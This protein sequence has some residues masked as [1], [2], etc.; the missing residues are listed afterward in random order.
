M[1]LSWRENFI[2]GY[3]GLISSKYCFEFKSTLSTF[4][5]LRLIIFHFLKCHIRSYQENSEESIKQCQVL[6]EE[7][8][9]D[10]AVRIGDIYGFMIEHYASKERWKAVRKKSEIIFLVA[11]PFC[12]SS[13]FS[14]SH[15]SLLYFFKIYN[16]FSIP[17]LS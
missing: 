15:F 9:L 11:F 3:H 5:Y 10:A 8:D 17:I 7:Q 6:L 12:L 2:R 16:S 1:T 14:L 4:S 13:S